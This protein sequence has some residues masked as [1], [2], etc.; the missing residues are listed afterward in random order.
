MNVV[1]QE[2]HW[3]IRLEGEL[4]WGCAVELR[5]LLLA[6]RA[7]GKDLELDCSG[8]SELDVT[9]LQLLEAARREARQGNLRFGGQE[10]DAVAMAV[11]GA[12]F[13]DLDGCLGGRRE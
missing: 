7:A 6:W 9:I 4:N 11:R 5:T 3:V 10:S 2:P 1:Q 12:G 8:V 13:A